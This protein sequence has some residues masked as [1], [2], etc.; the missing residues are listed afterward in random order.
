ML[1]IFRVSLSDN[2]VPI[3]VCEVGGCNA[4]QGAA[5]AAVE[6]GDSFVRDDLVYGVEGGGVVSVVGCEG[7]AF[8]FTAAYLD[9]Q[10]GFYSANC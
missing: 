4:K 10:S 2:G 5:E 7:D 6:A 3:E 9:L 8:G 1:C